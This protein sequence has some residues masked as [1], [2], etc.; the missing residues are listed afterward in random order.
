MPEF[1]KNSCFM[2]SACQLP[3]VNSAD[4]IIADDCVIVKGNYYCGCNAVTFAVG[5][6]LTCYVLGMILLKVL[7]RINYFKCMIPARR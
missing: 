2:A 6:I 4:N 3:C 5:E 1:R 7:P